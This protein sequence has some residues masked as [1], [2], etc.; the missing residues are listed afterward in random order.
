MIHRAANA[1]LAASV[2]TQ[3]KLV[4]SFGSVMGAVVFGTLSWATSSR[5]GPVSPAG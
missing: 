1:A 5:T 4:T 2:F 3:L